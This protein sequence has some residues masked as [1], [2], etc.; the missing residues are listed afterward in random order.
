[1]KKLILFSIVLAIL[2]LSLSAA[3]AFQTRFI[4]L[5]QTAEDIYFQM[6]YPYTNLKVPAG[7]VVEFTI[8]RAMYG[9]VKVYACGLEVKGTLDL[10][11]NLK[12]N[13]TPCEYMFQV[14]T[15][16]YLGEPSMEKVNF[17]LVPGI[18]WQFRYS[19]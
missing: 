10:T 7:E 8:N 15:P 2:V 14:D 5:N 1:M 13:F 11:R 9:D 17:F 16:K 12:L 19:K 3:N 6:A 18:G 4:V